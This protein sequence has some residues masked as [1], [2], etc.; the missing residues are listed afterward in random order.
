MRLVGKRGLR[1]GNMYQPMSSSV[2]RLWAVLLTVVLVY[3]PL[4]PSLYAQE[5]NDPLVDQRNC[6]RDGGVW[7]GDSCEE[8]VDLCPNVPGDQESEPCADTQCEAGGGT[9]NTDTCEYPPTPEE[10]CIADGGTWEADACTY[11]PTPE[12]ECVAAG[13]TW[14]GNSCDMPAEE[15]GNATT[16]ETSID[17]N[18]GTTTEEIIDTGTGTTTEEVIDTGTGEE[19]V[20]TD[21]SAPETS[22]TDS[23][24]VD[25]SESDTDNTDFED[26]GEASAP[27]PEKPLIDLSATSTEAAAVD[28]QFVVADDNDGTGS[29]TGGIVLTGNAKATTRIKNTL[30]VTRSN[31]DGPGKTNSSNITASAENFADLTTGTNT[32]ALSGENTATGGTQG[33]ALISTGKSVAT[34]EV[35]NVVNTNIFN[36]DG[37]VLF[38]NPFNGDGF[39]LRDFDLSY[40][41]D[42]GP[43]ASPTQYGCTILT[44]L[45]SSDL[46]VLNK[47]EAD[48]L[49]TVEVSA[50]TGKNSAT[51]QE[52]GDAD[53]T[54]GDAYAA[55]NVLN[56]VNTNFVNSSYLLVAFN[57]F[58]DLNDD[59]VLPGA[60]FFE[61][62]LANGSSFPEMNSSSYVV[63]N[64]NDENFFG[65]T[66]ANA[67]TGGNIATT[68]AAEHEGNGE[69]RTGN[70]YSSSQSYTA[71]NQT[72]V[73][74]S[75]VLLTFRVW[76]EWS[77]SIQGLPAGMSW[78]A[79]RSDD[80]RSWLIEIISTGGTPNGSK[81]IFNS[82][83]F[84]A[85]STN[86]ANVRTDVNVWAITG[87]NTTETV[88]GVGRIHTGD[89]YAAAN[90]I[91]MVNTN[92]VSRNWV[93]GSFNIFGDWSG[94]IAFGGHS[95]DLAVAIGVNAP[96]PTVTS[97]DV[98]YTF[99]VENNG[100]VS[101]ENVVLSSA[102]SKGA[103]QYMRGS[104]GSTETTAGRGWDIGTL[105]P[106]ESRVVS[107][108]MRVLVGDIEEGITV[109]IPMTVSVTSSGH[110]Q[111]DS[112]NT[113]QATITVSSSATGG[114]TDDDTGSGR[115]E[116]EDPRAT[117]GDESPP[118]PPPAPT[119][120][121]G[122]PAPAPPPPSN[123]SGSS[124][125]PSPPP[126]PSPGGG[127]SP[128]T[129]GGGG[130]GGGGVSFGGGT[131]VGNITI[132]KTHEGDTFTS[133]ATVAYK[134]VV[135]NNKYAGPTYQTVLTD[136]LYN[137]KGEVVSDRSWDLDV[138]APGDQVTL[139]YSAA[140]GTTTLPG[141]Y[142]N[143]A[144]VTAKI[145]NPGGGGG[146]LD[147]P[148]MMAES[149]VE[150]LPNG[151]VLGDAT[152]TIDIATS[153]VKIAK[154]K[155]ADS[156]GAYITKNLYRG[157]RE[158][159]EIKKLQTFLNA[160][161]GADLPV[162]GVFGPLTEKTVKEFQTKYANEILYPLG[163]RRATG[164]VYASTIHKINELVCS[165][166]YPELI[167]L[168]EPGTTVSTTGTA[169]TNPAPS[170]SPAS[171]GSAQGTSKTSEDE[172]GTGIFAVKGDGLIGTLGGVFSRF[173]PSLW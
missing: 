158:T 60:S 91:N 73:G 66:T 143:V 75:S 145:N 36:S 51:A 49:N 64:I 115:D 152:S 132:Y 130:G 50:R 148:P 127:A 135:E 84:V 12:E 82:S 29:K 61:G 1:E 172:R 142:K 39:D 116:R 117:P 153:T 27:D 2:N 94:D 133:P 77:G 120:G 111:D 89:A 170:P 76:G 173:V 163:L 14:N 25:P 28:P 18:T 136:I 44:C 169:S 21:E 141:K 48:V 122:S 47:N 104:S 65:T 35:M 125:P 157:S 139:T 30:N 146:V 31:V 34:A 131:G 114:S 109:P 78:R 168:T 98:E 123:G 24:Q 144:R 106:G 71:A 100:D 11:P 33:S 62:L 103:L 3:A 129:V 87:E 90:V 147:M 164:G 79:T 162:I 57:N 110:D 67:I 8:P 86:I 10:E 167:A 160:E 134:V 9:W 26:I 112:D 63:D 92:I 15:T 99:T 23:A 56:L 7:D 88:D 69:I 37:L 81:G 19:V 108:T 119:G 52:S 107:A 17:T 93:F 41:F 156:C 38:L 54:T 113:A 128:A 68:T 16:T 72:R 42:E 149:I 5:A 121:G 22:S 43:G 95:P 165:G 118:P 154:G 45:N 4:A 126:S 161:M 85:S 55:A 140:F 96:E 83:Q 20:I 105:A 137:P 151:I 166:K 101:A 40:F 159:E 102:Y 80:N 124:P 46:N 171:S 150:L 97:S 6:E 53:I 155:V 138:M 58:G 13:G 74:G 70:A 59:I 32:N